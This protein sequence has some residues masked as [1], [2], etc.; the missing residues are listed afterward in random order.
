MTN[1][2]MIWTLHCVAADVDIREITHIPGES[3][4]TC[5]Q[6]SRRGAENETSVLEHAGIFG[7]VSADELKF[8]TNLD[9][10]YLLR[11]CDPAIGID[12]DGEFKAF[13]ATARS[14]IDV[15]LNLLSFASTCL[16]QS[17]FKLRTEE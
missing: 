16:P 15:I 8:E 14:H 6:F 7:I 4:D 10:M 9:V 2:A 11:L 3:N 12:S 13:W 5:D 17:S 1:A